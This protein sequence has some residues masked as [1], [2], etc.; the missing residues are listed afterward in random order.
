MSGR[1]GPG[2][3]EG[4]ETFDPDW[5]SLREPVDHRSRADG[6]LPLLT[7]AW[8][9][10]GWR[11]IVDL[12]AGAGSNLRYLA[13]RLP[14]PQEWVLV[15]HDAGLLSRAQ[16]PGKGVTVRRVVGDLARE[17]LEAMSDVD[18]VVGAAL[19]DLT[20]EV[21]LRAV[22]DGCRQRSLGALFTTSYDGTV[23]WNREEADVGPEEERDR[24][25]RDLVNAHQRRDK[26]LGGALGP[27]AAAAAHRLFQEA[28]MSTWLVPAPWILTSGDADLVDLLVDGWVA[29]ARDQD[30]TI[31]SWVDAWGAARKREVRAGEAR[32]TV[33]HL[34]LL[35]LP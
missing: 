7:R 27:D 6:L 17:G 11:R 15:D 23:A 3:P 2:G 25:V 26:G 12:G 4:P 5:L 14:G 16:P 33:G 1:T 28:G 29:A 35:A 19:L 8:R 9:A 24:R 20:S 30:S 22:V 18:L 21:W 34:D 31:T 32:V 10:R 13:P